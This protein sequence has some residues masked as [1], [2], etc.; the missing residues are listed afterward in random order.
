MGKD[1]AGNQL[2]PRF[3]NH[4]NAIARS[5]RKNWQYLD[6]VFRIQNES[7]PLP[8]RRQQQ[9]DLH[10]REVIPDALPR[11]GAKREVRILRYLLTVFPTL[12]LER[13]RLLEVT[14]I[15][16]RHPLKRKEL[17]AFWHAITANLRFLDCLAPDRIRRRI[18]THRFLRN[19][20][21][22]FQLRKI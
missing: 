17:R 13:I 7:K 8:D 11:A 15:A 19:H 4:L 18:E 10:H 14:R 20:L 1:R 2:N 22:V 16:V 9:N 12:R 6:F 21:R 3:N 5:K